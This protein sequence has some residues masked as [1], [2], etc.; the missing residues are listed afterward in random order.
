MIEETDDILQPFTIMIIAADRTGILPRLVSTPWH[1]LL[2]V[3]ATNRNQFSCFASFWLAQDQQRHNTPCTPRQCHKLPQK[4][5]RATPAIR[6][7]NETTSESAPGACTGHQAQLR[8]QEPLATQVSN[9]HHSTCTPG[10]GPYP[11][12]QTCHHQANLLR[13]TTPCRHAGLPASWESKESWGANVHAAE[14][15][16]SC[17][18]LWLAASNVYTLAFLLPCGK[19]L[20]AAHP[21]ALHGTDNFH[22]RTWHS[23]FPPRKTY[24]AWACFQR[25]KLIQSCWAKSSSQI[26]AW[27]KTWIIRTM[28]TQFTGIITVFLPDSS[29][30]DLNPVRSSS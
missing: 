9:Q 16:P 27:W 17:K 30:V 11:L 14:R 23:G 28:N 22:M 4:V 21:L 20:E 26:N 13:H 24:F 12:L 7:W 29:D 25:W 2:D 8:Q 3:H 10:S 15:I 6:W 19:S 18:E 1:P 5:Q